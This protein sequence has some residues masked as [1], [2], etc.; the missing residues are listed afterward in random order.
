MLAGMP[1]SRTRPARNRSSALGNAYLASASAT[2]DTPTRMTA[3]RAVESRYE[4]RA[5]R[6]AS[7]VRILLRRKVKFNC[8]YGAK[9]YKAAAE[10]SQEQ[11]RAVS[12]P[13][14]NA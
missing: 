7:S 10:F 3:M 13:D 9:G 1:R 8:L 14:K 6:V 2:N 4:S 5:N 12:S 11:V